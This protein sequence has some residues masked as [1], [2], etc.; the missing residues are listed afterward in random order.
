[1]ADTSRGKVDP[2]LKVAAEQEVK[3]IASNNTPSGLVTKGERY[4]KVM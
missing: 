2:F 1:M 4:N 3:E